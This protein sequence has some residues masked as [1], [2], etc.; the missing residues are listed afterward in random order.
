MDREDYMTR[1]DW[2]VQYLLTLMGVLVVG[3]ALDLGIQ[4]IAYPGTSPDSRGSL[5]SIRMILPK[6]LDSLGLVLGFIYS[7]VVFFLLG[8]MKPKKRRP[9]RI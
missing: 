9:V 4:L 6:P 2:I 1:N 8:A 5:D 3:F 7:L